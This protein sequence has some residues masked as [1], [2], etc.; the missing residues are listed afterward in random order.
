MEETTLEGL[1]GR[2]RPWFE[3]RHRGGTT[4]TR[5]TPHCHLGHRLDH[6]GRHGPDGVFAQWD[7]DGHRLVVRNDRYG[8][9]PLFYA[10]HGGMIRVSPSIFQ[11][12]DG[13]VPRTL[14]DTALAVFLR[15]GFFIGEATPFECVH[16]L[17][18]GSTLTWQD[19]ACS[20]ERGDPSV[21]APDPPVASFDEAVERYIALFRQAIARRPPPEAGF[22]LPISGGRDSR[23]ILFELL[24]QGHPPAGTVTVQ[25]RPPSAN[26]DLRIARILAA[27]LGLENVQ[28]AM[29]RDYFAASRKDIELTQLCGSGHTWLLPV[30]AWLQA[31]G[32]QTLYDGLAGSVLSGGF[33]VNEEKLALARAGHTRK[34]A[35]RLLR[36]NGLQPFLSQALRPPMD[37]RLDEAPAMEA[38]AAELERH[39]DAPHPLM[40]FIFWN[41]TRRGISLIPFSILG[42]VETVY[43]PYLDHDLFDFLFHLDAGYSMGNAL[44]DEALRR[45]YPQY[46]HLPFEDPA[47]PKA[48]MSAE[49]AHYRRAVRGFLAE[50]ARHPGRLGSR[51]VRFERILAMLTRDLLRPRCP[52]TWYLQPALYLLELE[53]CLEAD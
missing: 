35:T 42:S 22:T 51:M 12:L 8:I 46:A 52:R 33:Q 27:E 53:A 18:P 20:L 43:C 30:A 7:W 39:V 38:V 6:G 41:R 9:H 44:H 28:I 19:G 40:S 48:P 49:S 36:E 24:T 23:H 4:H 2:R 47:A 34:L 11:V 10:C 25:S 21:P 5:G 13:D 50:F 26:E 16:V 32:V 37:R 17:P 45:G 31:H 14:D 1:C 3:V 29:P 15:L